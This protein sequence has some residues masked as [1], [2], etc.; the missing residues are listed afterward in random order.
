[1][2]ILIYI[3]KENAVMLYVYTPVGETGVV[4]EGYYTWWGIN[5]PE[6]ATPHLQNVE[7]KDVITSLAFKPYSP[8]GSIK[9]TT[10]LKTL[11]ESYKLLFDDCVY[12]CA[13]TLR[14]GYEIAR[15]LVVGSKT[16]SPQ[17]P[18]IPHD[19]FEECME[20]P[21]VKVG[22]LWSSWDHT[23]LAFH[24]PNPR[25]ALQLPPHAVHVT[26]IEH[27]VFNDSGLH[28]HNWHGYCMDEL[29][30]GEKCPD[31]E[32]WMKV[33]RALNRKDLELCDLDIPFEVLEDE[34]ERI[35]NSLDIK[36]QQEQV[37][38]N[39]EIETQDRDE[40]DT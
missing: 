23:V 28:D 2:D 27:G 20:L 16:R 21:F 33:R 36:Q 6:D 35:R 37:M 15:V 26:Q 19:D 31:H 34:V 10:S 13:G 14:Y 4:I 22:K 5:L 9:F 39:I 7:E 40:D 8:Y 25:M 30:D 24:F 1:M 29:R 38:R 12:K 32:L 18:I 17:F 3:K 11:L